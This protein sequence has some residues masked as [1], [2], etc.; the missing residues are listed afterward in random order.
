MGCYTVGEKAKIGSRIASA[1][2][3]I[4][5]GRPPEVRMTDAPP[6]AG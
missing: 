5:G 1:T 4:V 2:C 3:D 6:S